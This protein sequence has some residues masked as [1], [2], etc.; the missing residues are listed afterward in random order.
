M[1]HE[2]L[3]HLMQAHQGALQLSD[4]ASY[5]ALYRQAAPDIYHMQ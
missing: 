2:R 3:A 4:N 1:S 5:Q